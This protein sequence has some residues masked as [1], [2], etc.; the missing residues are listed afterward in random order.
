[1]EEINVLTESLIKIEDVKEEPADTKEH[2]WNTFEEFEPPIAV[3]L[4]DPPVK[5]ETACSDEEKE[6]HSSWRDSVCGAEIKQDTTSCSPDGESFASDKD[7]KTQPRRSKSAASDCIHKSSFSEYGQ[8]MDGRLAHTNV[9]ILTGKKPFQ[10]SVQNTQKWTAQ[11]HMRPQADEKC[12]ISEKA[13]V[14]EGGSR[15]HFLNRT[16]EKVFQCSVCGKAITRKRNLQIHMR[17]H[18]GEKPF[19]CSFCEKNFYRREDFDNHLRTHTGERPFQC[20]IC[21]KRFT[22]N[23]TLRGHM[24]IHT[25]EKPFQCSI[26][27]KAF[28]LKC[29][30]LTHMRTHS[31]EKPF[32]CCICEKAFSLKNILQKH[33]RIHMGEKPF[34]CSFCEKTFYEKKVLDNHLRTHS[35]ETP[36]QCSVCEK[37]FTLENNLRTCVSIWVKILSSVPS[38]KRPST[39]KRTLIIIRAL[40]PIK[41]YFLR[42]N[43]AKT[44]HT[45]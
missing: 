43:C 8:T 39:E 16:N 5:Q 19:Q 35:G 29:N 6:P 32:Q 41:T 1:M 3:S 2:C 17:I 44:C 20:S 22:Q 4:E 28:T 27:E 23:R 33:M 34:Q 31:G 10:C 26:C 25:G 42:S 37:S 38:V 24:L 13:I 12:S 7:S 11:R 36:F 9:R 15:D 30:L 21:E 40:T 14:K 45:I 18:T